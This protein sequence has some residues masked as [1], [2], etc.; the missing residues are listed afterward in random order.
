[1][2]NSPDFWSILNALHSIPEAAP[3]VF[4]IVEEV[5]TGS[6]SALSAD[7]YEAAVG[8]LNGFA[9]A[10]SIGAIQEQARDQEGRKA[11]AGRDGK[12]AKPA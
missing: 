10:A 5:V 9:G 3:T 12:E 1:M 2:T 7:N 8:L 6:P 4:D 11:K